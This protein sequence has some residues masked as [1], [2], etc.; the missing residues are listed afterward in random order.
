MFL[1]CSEH[2]TDKL[3]FFTS[4]FHYNLYLKWIISI[5]SYILS[6]WNL[7]ETKIVSNGALDPFKN[8]LNSSPEN[9][10]SITGEL[11]APWLKSLFNL[12]SKIF[13]IYVIQIIFLFRQTSNQEFSDTKKSVTVEFPGGKV[14]N[15]GKSNKK[16]VPSAN[17]DL[18]REFLTCKEEGRERLNLSKSNISSL[19]P[20]LKVIK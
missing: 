13:G 20:T 17:L 11:T 5:I 2:F 16:R 6:L 18:P 9:K 1:F 3:D 8:L 15:T 19:P 14:K 12:Y 4:H 10:F 7:F